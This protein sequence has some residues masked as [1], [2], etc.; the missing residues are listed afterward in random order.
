MSLQFNVSVVISTYNRCDQL[1]RALESLLVQETGGVSYEVIAVDNNSTDRTRQVI[2]SFIAR[3]HSNLRYVFEGRQGA[4]HGKNAGI[5]Q[6]R[7][8]IIAFTD[9]DV[10][11]ASDWIANIKRAFDAHPEAGCVSGTIVP[12]WPSS[13]P[14]WLTREHWVGP[15]ALQD[16]G[17]EPFFVNAQRPI[18][19]A[20]ANY[21]FRSAVLQQIGIFSPEVSTH[22]DK[23]DTELLLRFWRNNGQCLYVPSIVV[24]AEVQPDRLTKEYHRQWYRTAGEF[25]A[26]MNLGEIIDRDGQL[27]EEPCKSPRLFG[28]PAFM[29]RQLATESIG[30]LAAVLRRQEIRSFSHESRMNYLIGYIGKRFEQHGAERKHSYLAELRSF[31]AAMLHKQRC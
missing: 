12:H 3:G 1:P 10:R 7:G 30:Y 23:S 15:L 6:A 28:V 18:S 17:D 24:T 11:V 4:A 9:D 2:E 5:R 16:Y 14:E 20:S 19:L 26:L 25:G 8:T 29:Y 21:S 22:A 13:P 31:A 27:S